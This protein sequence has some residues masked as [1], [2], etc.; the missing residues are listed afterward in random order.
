MSA[1]AVIGDLGALGTFFTTALIAV[2]LYSTNQDQRDRF[3]DE[4]A[5]EYRRLIR[6]MPVEALL[7]EEIPGDS[8][9]SRLHL[10]YPYFDLCNE[11]VGMRYDG[12]LRDSTWRSWQV[13]IESNLGRPAINAAW[14]EIR[15]KTEA[16]EHSKAIFRELKLFDDRVEKDP[17][18]WDGAHRRGL[19]RLSRKGQRAPASPLR[20]PSTEVQDQ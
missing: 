18:R 2:Q 19:K 9:R 8:E 10:Y 1:G 12:R 11:Q 6:D 16:T 4:L 13:G 3:E 5:S 15:K 7:G 17:G 20:G 14:K